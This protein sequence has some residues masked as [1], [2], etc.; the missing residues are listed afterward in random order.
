MTEALSSE[1]NHEH[2]TNTTK[3]KDKDVFFGVPVVGFFRKKQPKEHQ[4]LTA[5]T[6]QKSVRF[7]FND[8][9]LFDEGEEEDD[10]YDDDEDED[11]EM[12]SLASRQ[13][14][15]MSSYGSLGESPKK[16]RSG[17]ELWAIV[18]R[19][20]YRQDFH[21]RDTVRQTS[22]LFQS[23]RPGSRDADALH[24]R[25]IDLPYDFT[26]LDCFLALAAYLAISVIAYSFVFEQW[27]VIDSMYFAVVTFTT[28]GYGDFSPTTT[29]GRL[30]CVLFALGGVAVLAIALG[31]VGHK[32]VES[33]VSSIS[34]AETQFVDDWAKAFKKK[35]NA[36]QRRLAYAKHGH[37][38]SGDSASGSSFSYLN[39]CDEVG[40]T[41]RRRA[42]EIKSPWH[43]TM[44]WLKKFGKMLCTCTSFAFALLDE[45]CLVI[46]GV[47]VA[48]LTDVCL[49]P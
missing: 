10:Y 6:T 31:V 36:S 18:R 5:S 34:K 22:S 41:I 49:F 39:E 42:L 43:S 16:H 4:S 35:M 27:S 23:V 29:G 40:Y 25:D 2:R 7:Q 37:S 9:T 19:H 28:I 15:R 30:F 45:S 38:N 48:G 3:K 14:Q 32:I 20:V 1:H 24:F 17:K 47:F 21:I 33:Q 8:N 26:L 13:F 11:E 12:A 46:Y 44:E